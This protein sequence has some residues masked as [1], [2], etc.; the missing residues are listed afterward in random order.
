M[1]YG[2]LISIII[3][4]YNVAPYLRDCLESVV[5]QTYKNLEI[6]LI[7][8]GST[9]GSDIIC[10]E[11]ANKDSRIILV[12]QVNRGLSAARN[13]GLEKS[14]GKAIAFLDGD[15][16]FH[17]EYI[18]TLI[19]S[20]IDYNTDIAICRYTLI[21]ET[22]ECVDVVHLITR[23]S[24][25]SG[26][27][28]RTFVLR[29]LVHGG[30]NHSVWN[31]VYK[32][33]LWQGIRFPEGRVYEDIDTM[34]RV[35]DRCKSICVLDETLYYYRRRAGSITSVPSI[36]KSKDWI[37]SQTHFESYISDNIPTI[38][39]MEDLRFARQNRLSQMVSYYIKYFDST[40]TKTLCFCED[41]R[42][43]IRNLLR[44]I[45]TEKLTMRKRFLYWM[46]CYC[47]HLLK[48]SHKYH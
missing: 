21:Q 32:A 26:I 1:I 45:T 7:D 29:D 39:S 31:K 30:V 5:A 40:E 6:I 25:H 47:P 4:V 24:I 2:D 27:Y 36:E 12:R 14:T 18:I 28:D 19:T 42:K 15:D 17:P 9:D 37:S 38:Y 34:F 11:Y 46:I 41:L 43:S 10:N 16:V 48:I 13:V 44:E 8:D 23:P 22:E 33:Y 20:I 3:P 35:F